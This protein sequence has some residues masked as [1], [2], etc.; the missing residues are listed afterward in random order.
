MPVIEFGLMGVKP[1]HKA[2]DQTTEEGQVLHKAWTT[3]TV[4][5]GGPHWAYGGLEVGNPLL[6]WGFFAFDSVEQHQEF[7]KM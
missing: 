3:V 5:P 1:N 4:A 7:A 6:L 2:M